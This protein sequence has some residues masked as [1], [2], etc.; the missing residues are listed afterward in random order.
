MVFEARLKRLRE[1]FGTQV[2]LEG[3][4]LRGEKFDFVGLN[5]D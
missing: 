4:L 5:D 1:L 2:R 3:V